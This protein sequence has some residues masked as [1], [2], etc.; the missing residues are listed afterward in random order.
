MVIR[1]KVGK[2]VYL[3]LRAERRNFHSYPSH[4]CFTYIPEH[5]AIPA[6]LFCTGTYPYPSHYCFIYIPEHGL[7]TLTISYFEPLTL[8]DPECAPSGRAGTTVW[9]LP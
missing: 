3:K 2:T 4:Y 5:T 9:F 1:F 7:V 8:L 6:L